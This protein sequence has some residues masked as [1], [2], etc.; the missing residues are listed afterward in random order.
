VAAVA[1]GLSLTPLK[2]IIIIKIMT[3]LPTMSIFVFLASIGELEDIPVSEDESVPAVN[4]NVTIVDVGTNTV[5][6]RNLRV[7]SPCGERQRRARSV[8]LRKVW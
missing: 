4:E 6:V 1:S 3:L 8:K 2:I 7:S 5:Q